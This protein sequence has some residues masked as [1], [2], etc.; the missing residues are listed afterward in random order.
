MKKCKGK[1]LDI[2]KLELAIAVINEFIVHN[3]LAQSEEIGW[4]EKF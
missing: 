1:P 2:D 4:R 3:E